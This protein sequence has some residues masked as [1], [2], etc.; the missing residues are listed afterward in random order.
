MRKVFKALRRMHRV[1]IVHRDI[2]PV[3]RAPTLL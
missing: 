1:G 3:G 2:K